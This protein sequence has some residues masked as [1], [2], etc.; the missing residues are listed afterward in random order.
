MIT[1]SGKQALQR[2]LVFDERILKVEIVLE[3]RKTAV[4][5]MSNGKII[6]KAP[7]QADPQQLL[8]WLAGK[9]QWIQK[10]VNREEL[11]KINDNEI[12]IL[13]QK[14]SVQIVHT[15]GTLSCVTSEGSSLIVNVKGNSNVSQVMEKY[16]R[17]E[18][19]TVLNQ[20]LKQC[21]EIT[22]LRP[23]ELRIKKMK[24]SWGR[25]SSTRI[26]TLNTNLIHC[27]PEFIH[28]VCIHELMHLKVMNH[29]KKFWDLVEKYES[30]YKRIRKSGSLL[31][32]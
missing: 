3:N 29:S 16:L 13:G 8:N 23:D 22:G 11:H 27:T 25:C 14:K 17:Y 4:A 20:I 10:Q 9:H 21:Y 30:E 31:P 5:R 15:K 1:K 32:M 18:A 19:E 2:E 28:Y 24:R 26:I 6:L 12:W 7:S